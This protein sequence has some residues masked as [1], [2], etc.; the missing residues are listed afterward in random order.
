M[1]IT[2]SGIDGSGKSTLIG[3]LRAALEADHGPVVVRHINHDI[4][5]YAAVQSLRDRLLRRP[6]AARP[7]GVPRP[8]DWH[9][10]AGVGFRARARWGRLRHALIWNK[11]LRRGVYLADLLIF[12]V[13]RFY[14]ERVRRRV[15][16]MDRYFYDTL[17]DVADPQGWLWARFLAR[18]TPTPSLAV[19]LDL[20]PEEAFARKGEYTVDYLARRSLAYKR[21]FRWVRSA[22]VLEQVDL[23]GTTRELV[24]LVENTAKR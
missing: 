11:P 15:L 13:F 3:S 17:V 19:L 14:I 7:A 2:F 1:L 24:R 4:G 16:I 22:V 12:V 8:R 6:R 20:S 18:L 23:A 10:P 5:L 9:G 21:V